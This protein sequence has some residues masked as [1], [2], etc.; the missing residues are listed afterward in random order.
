MLT[1]LMMM[2]PNA[3]VTN[4]GVINA[5]VTNADVT[6]GD[7]TNDDVTYDDVTNNDVINADYSSFQPWCHPLL[8]SLPVCTLTPHSACLP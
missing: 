1:S 2:S 4:A 7:V 8:V 6:H 5:D 3:D